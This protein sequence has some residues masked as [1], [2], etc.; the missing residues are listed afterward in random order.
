MWT[1]YDQLIESIPPKEKITAIE[2]TAR[3]ILVVTDTYVGTAMKFSHEMVGN[4][5]KYIGA[6]LQTVAELIKSWDFQQASIGLAAINSY[7]N[8]KQQLKE[9]QTL[10]EID[11]QDAFDEIPTAVA[12]NKIGMIGHFPYVDRV[13][14]IKKQLSIFE[15][16]PKMGDLPA[17]AS[18]FLLPQMDIVYIT[19]S[20]IVNKTLPRL[21]TLSQQAKTVLVGSSCPLSSTFFSQGVQVIAGTLYNQ[22]IIE[23]VHTNQKRHLPLSKHGKQL[24]ITQ[25]G[26]EVN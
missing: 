9:N 26:V 8:R 5:E 7:L 18:E 22:E 14:E 16:E 19:A 21:L 24:R 20:T 17:S 6:E 4:L 1:L 12:T 23:L 25:K 15:L 13:P 11:Y 10:M 3:W 2:Q